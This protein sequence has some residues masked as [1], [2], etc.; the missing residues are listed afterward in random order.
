MSAKRRI[1]LV[2]PELGIE[3]QPMTI[4]LWFVR[5]GQRVVE[6]EPLVEILCGPATVD[7]PAPADGI[8]VKK[9]VV[10]GDPIKT[11]QVMGIIDVC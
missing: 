4:S 10:S 8:L 9:M 7:L 1:N 3:D 2:M 5:R 6:G 11:N